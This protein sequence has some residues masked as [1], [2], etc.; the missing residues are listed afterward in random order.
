MYVTRTPRRLK[1]EYQKRFVDINPT[2]SGSNILTLAVK[3][4]SPRTVWQYTVRG[5]SVLAMK[6]PEAVSG[7]KAGRGPLH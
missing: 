1:S 3:T 6:C 5:E 4:L 7:G 2:K